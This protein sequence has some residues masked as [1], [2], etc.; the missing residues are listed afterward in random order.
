LDKIIARKVGHYGYIY[1]HGSRLSSGFLP[2]S[3][4]VVEYQVELRI[5]LWPQQQHIGE[6][7]GEGN[8]GFD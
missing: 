3:V 2:A 7:E 5:R 6:R 4:L 8:L 1:F